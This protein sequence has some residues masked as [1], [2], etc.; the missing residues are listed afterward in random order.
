M[1]KNVDLEYLFLKNINSK[2]FGLMIIKKKVI[3]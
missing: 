1:R 3:K 2:G